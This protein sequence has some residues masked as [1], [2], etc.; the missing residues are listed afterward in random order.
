MVGALL[1]AGL[2]V[3]NVFRGQFADDEQVHQQVLG[4]W[5]EGKLLVN[6]IGHG[7][8]EGWRGDIFTSGD[9]ST[10]INAL[11]LPFVVIMTCLNGFFQDPSMDSFAEVLLKARQGGAVA[12]WSSSGLTEPEGQSAMDKE[13]VR[14]LFNGES[15]TLGEAVARAKSATGDGDVRRTWVL[16]GDPTTRLKY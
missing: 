6:Y 4:A 11:R 3:R 1:P 2:T 9:A 15:L 8:Q 14:V 7:S 13:L 5:N 10:L 16:F 12:V